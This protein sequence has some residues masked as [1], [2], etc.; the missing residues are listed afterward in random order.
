MLLDGLGG[1]GN[2]VSAGVGDG[3]GDGSGVGE[4]SG[5]GVGDGGSDV[6]SGVG[7]SVGGG[8]GGSVGVGGVAVSSVGKGGV[9]RDNVASGSDGQDGGENELRVKN[10]MLGWLVEKFLRW[11]K[12]IEI[13]FQIIFKVL[14][15]VCVLNKNLN[16]SKEYQKKSLRR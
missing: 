6:G 14:K 16:Q 2:L 5:G 13:C 3:G 9:V 11:G 7:S 8:V 1:V 15:F 10:H 4:G 12:S